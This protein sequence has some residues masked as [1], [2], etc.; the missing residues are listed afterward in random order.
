MSAEGEQALE[1]TWLSA[2]RLGQ[3]RPD[4]LAT[5]DSS[6]ERKIVE[7]HIGDPE[8]RPPRCTSPIRQ[9]DSCVGGP[10]TPPQRLKTRAPTVRRAHAHNC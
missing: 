4:R 10:M 7:I 8:S 9:A 6:F 2:N 3:A 5:R 1:I